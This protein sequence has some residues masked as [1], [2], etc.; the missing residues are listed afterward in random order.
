MRA[1]NTSTISTSL[2]LPENMDKETQGITPF[3]RMILT[4]KLASHRVTIDAVLRVLHSGK[5]IEVETIREML[6]T[7]DDTL[8]Y[9]ENPKQYWEDPT[10]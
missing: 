9:C 8:K 2:L 3:K 6:Q 10:C 4:Q 5:H 1:P 7:L